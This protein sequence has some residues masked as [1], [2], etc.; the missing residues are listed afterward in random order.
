MRSIQLQR[1][2][3]YLIEDTESYFR[4]LIKNLS[5]DLVNKD[6][7][8][9]LYLDYLD[10]KSGKYYECYIKKIKKNGNIIVFNSSLCKNIKT[11]IHT[12]N[13]GNKLQII[14]LIEDLTLKNLTFKNK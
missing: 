12:Y 8:D 11:N 6:E 13:L 9:Q 1:D 2:Y 4:E 14:E 7:Y 10:D 3:Y 5:N